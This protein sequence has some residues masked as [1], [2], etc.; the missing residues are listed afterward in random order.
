LST[1]PTS[2]NVKTE[3][4]IKEIKSSVCDLSSLIASRIARNQTSEKKKQSEL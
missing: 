4:E 3:E 2:I 1:V